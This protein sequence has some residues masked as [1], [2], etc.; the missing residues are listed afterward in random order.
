MVRPAYGKDL[1]TVEVY[2][3]ETGLVCFRHGLVS[4]GDSGGRRHVFERERED[5]GGAELVERAVLG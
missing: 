4:A 2:R 5:A 3:L 1:D